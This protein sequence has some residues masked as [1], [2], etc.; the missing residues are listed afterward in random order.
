MQPITP[1][2]IEDLQPR[3]P[4]QKHTCN[5]SRPNIAPWQYAAIFFFACCV[6][7]A[8][9]P[10]AILHAQFFAEDG[11]VWFA[12]AYNNG[13]WRAFFIAHAGYY[14]T[15]PRLGAA[16]AQLVPFSMAPLVLNCI[17][18]ALQAIPVALMLSSRSSGWGSLQFR[19]ALAVV[20]LALPNSLEVNAGIT[21][22]QWIL[23][24]TV[25]LLLV[26][27]VPR[28][29]AGRIF[30][31]S[32][33][34]LCGLTGPFCLLLLPIAL[35]Q[36][37]RDRDPWRWV[38]SAS[39]ALACLIQVWA[40]VVKDP[41]GR[42]HSAMLGAT[43]E[44]F[45][46]ILA[47]RIYL[48]T[49]LGNNTLATRS[50]RDSLIFLVC[51]AAIGTAIIVFCFAK[52]Q[53]EMKLLIAFSGVLFLVS[54]GSPTSQPL[55]PGVSVWPWMASNAGDR[56]WFFP[57]LAFAWSLAWLFRRPEQLLKIIST[58]LLFLMCIGMLRD[59]KHPAFYDLQFPTYA[60]RFAAAPQGAATSIPIN[61]PGW[62]MKLIKR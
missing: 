15:F 1:I 51:V 36:L 52:S 5:G 46:R 34:L 41:S 53:I 14:H 37:W 30:D 24:L 45:I 50:G 23:A 18:I 17:C 62:H 27:S 60:K 48:S 47:G 19:S 12:D 6:V 35:Y 57:T 26:A 54:L 7:I 39:L 44:W 20:Y 22:S 59:W 32:L 9:R 8:R 13:W 2:A 28:T 40:L 4:F 11:T 10:D 21:D 33:L 42:H 49:L 56:Y 61:P 16:F 58:S 55:V 3:T 29:T 25:Y 38:Q 43:P 31:L